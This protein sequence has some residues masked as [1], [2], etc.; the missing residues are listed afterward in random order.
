M[1][2]FVLED[3]FGMSL[4]PVEVK[5]MKSP[6]SIYL[7]HTR[8]RKIIKEKPK[9]GNQGLATERLGAGKPDAAGLRRHIAPA[10]R[11]SAGGGRPVAGER[12]AGCR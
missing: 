3:V 7:S 8:E 10:E 11:Y 5:S 1:P 9:G 2:D 4:R 12:R 6:P